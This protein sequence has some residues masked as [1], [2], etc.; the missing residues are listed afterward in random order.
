MTKMIEYLLIGAGIVVGSFLLTLFL[1]QIYIIDL[2]NAKI[3]LHGPKNQ[4]P[5]GKRENTK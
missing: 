1:L 5:Y 4:L 2:W 3:N